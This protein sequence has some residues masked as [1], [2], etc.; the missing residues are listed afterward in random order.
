MPMIISFFDLEI[1]YVSQSST[2]FTFSSPN[3]CNKLEKWPSQ[4]TTGKNN[5]QGEPG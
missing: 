2:T 5:T 1:L 4:P 3:H